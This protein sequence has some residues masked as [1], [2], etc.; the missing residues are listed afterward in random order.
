MKPETAID[1]LDKQL[2]E[3]GEDIVLRRI[4]G[5]TNQVNIDVVIRA[6]VRSP[7]NQQLVAG[8]SQTD[9]VVIMSPTQIAA[10]QWPG[11]TSPTAIHPE[12]PRG[13]GPN[14]D[15]VVIAGRTRKIE[16]VNA[17]FVGG[18]WV[19]ATLKVVGGTA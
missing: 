3:N 9:S 8:F 10:A 11:G 15:V 1:M 18:V 6:S 19:R 7:T 16:A 17:V 2:A 4:V 12:I 5:T 13:G 14:G